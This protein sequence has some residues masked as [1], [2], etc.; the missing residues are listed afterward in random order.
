M[1]IYTIYLMYFL[2]LF[3]WARGK[4]VEFIVDVQDIRFILIGLVLYCLSNLASK[5]LILLEWKN[6]SFEIVNSHFL[7][8]GI[9]F[10]LY[11]KLKKV[12]G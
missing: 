11:Y 4:N 12:D 6:D 1:T 10:F 2:A 9:G 3:F 8:L 7:L 5:M